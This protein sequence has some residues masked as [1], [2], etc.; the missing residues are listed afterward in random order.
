MTRVLSNP[1]FDNLS[2][3]TVFIINH[4]IVFFSSLYEW[5]MVLA[6]D[7]VLKQAVD[8]VI[9][10]ICYIHPIFFGLLLEWMGIVIA[11]ESCT[12]DSKDI[13]QVQ[14]LLTDDLKADNEAREIGR[15]IGATPRS[16]ASTDLC[17][18]FFVPGDRTTRSAR[19][20]LVDPGVG[21]PVAGGTD[22]VDGHRLRCDAVSRSVRDR[23]QGAD[24]EGRIGSHDGGGGYGP[25]KEDGRR[26]KCIFARK[27]KRLVQR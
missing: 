12:D 27:T 13:Q 23:V 20:A 3:F 26:C 7:C 5:S 19:V 11:S 14:S 2:S 25:R 22:A 9:C 10:S 24:A 21:M 18:S 15:H 8:N 17:H 4:E 1:L 6:S 16:L